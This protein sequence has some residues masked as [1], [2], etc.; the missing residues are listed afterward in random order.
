MSCYK[1]ILS[2]VTL[3]QLTHWYHTRSR[4]LMDQLLYMSHPS[5]SYYFIVAQL[6]TLKALIYRLATGAVCLRLPYTF[7]SAIFFKFGF[8]SWSNEWN[9][10]SNVKKKKLQKTDYWQRNGGFTFWPEERITCLIDILALFSPIN[11]FTWRGHILPVNSLTYIKQ[12]KCVCKFFILKYFFSE[13]G[14]CRI[15][16]HFLILFQ[17]CSISFHC[18]WVWQNADTFF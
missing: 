9:V 4:Y 11:F 12:Q 2:Q 6:Y 3:S 10:I 7:R 18:N 15:T 1:G 14:F 5:N 13:S 17:K 16:S 8:L